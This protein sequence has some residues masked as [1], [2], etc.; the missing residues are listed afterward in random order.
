[1]QSSARRSAFSFCLVSFYTTILKMNGNQAGTNSRRRNHPEHSRN[2][3]QQARKKIFKK[4]LDGFLIPH[5][6]LKSTERS[7]CAASYQFS[8]GGHEARRLQPRRPTAV[9]CSA[10]LNEAAN[11]AEEERFRPADM[12]CVFIKVFARFMC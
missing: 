3:Y 5:G 12:V 9:R 7:K 8:E 6:D 1:M 4:L 2:T 10:W 11:A